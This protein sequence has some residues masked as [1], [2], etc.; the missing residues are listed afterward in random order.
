MLKKSF[1]ILLSLSV[2]IP[3]TSC[4]GVDDTNFG[5]ITFAS[6]VGNYKGSLII[7]TTFIA[8]QDTICTSAIDNNLNIIV[9]N[10]QYI[11]TRD[12]AD[13]FGKDTLPLIKTETINGGRLFSFATNNLNLIYYEKD[14]LVS[15]EN[16]VTNDNITVL[17]IFEGSK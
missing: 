13:V 12:E 17:D 3:I 11:V 1:I 15:L 16:K 6:I 7:C 14:K 4:E 10:N 2:L 9:M 5:V 8:A